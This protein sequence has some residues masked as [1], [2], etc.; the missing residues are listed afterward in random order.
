[1]PSCLLFKAT[2]HSLQK[3]GMFAGTFAAGANVKPRLTDSPRRAR[4]SRT[5]QL[6]RQ[7]E[8][9]ASPNQP[10]P[11]RSAYIFPYHPRGKLKHCLVLRSPLPRT[12]EYL[13]S[14]KSATTEAV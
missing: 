11:A 5:G 4:L 9:C 12:Q 14:L 13:L 2:K 3:S 10:P 6:V 7:W 1:M 8:F